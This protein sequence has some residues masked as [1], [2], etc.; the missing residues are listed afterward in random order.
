MEKD[1]KENKKD[2]S[3]GLEELRKGRKK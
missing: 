3:A 2:T 1:G